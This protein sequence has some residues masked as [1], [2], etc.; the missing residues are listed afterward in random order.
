MGRLE[1]PIP[2]MADGLRSAAVDLEAK[3][4]TYVPQE[5]KDSIAVTVYRKGRM[6]GLAIAY[7]DRAEN[8]VYAALEYPASQSRE[9]KVDPSR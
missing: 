7:D 2:D 8:L 4:K 6:T 5:Y 1:L 9:E 3:I